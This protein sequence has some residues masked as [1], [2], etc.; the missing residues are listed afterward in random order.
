MKAYIPPV[1]EKSPAVILALHGCGGSSLMHR[2]AANYDREASRKGFIVV[3]PSTTNDHH[4]WDVSSNKS[5]TYEGGGDSTGLANM[6]RYMMDKYNADPMRIFVQGT[7]SGCMMTNVLLATY[8]DIFRGGSC[9]SGL[10]AGCLAGSPGSSAQKSNPACAFGE[11][12]KTGEEW[13]K[14]VRGMRPKWDGG[15]PRLQTFHGTG[16]EFISYNN[17]GEQLKQWSTIHGINFTRNF[18]D[19]PQPGDTRMAY[20]DGSLLV[21]IS[22]NYGGHPIPV[23]V[24]ADLDW[25]GLLE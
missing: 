7:S 4:C 5:L 9:Y 8:P 16:D 20:G 24:D 23:D 13:A 14:I 19:S 1:L 10:P 3:Y 12:I 6:M 21:G 25:F 18:T 22:V 2:V 17:L 11:N 15:Y